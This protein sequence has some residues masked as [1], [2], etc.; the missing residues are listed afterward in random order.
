MHNWCIP[1]KAAIWPLG[2]VGERFVRDLAATLPLPN[3]T[4]HPHLTAAVPS[5]EIRPAKFDFNILSSFRD[6]IPF[7]PHESLFNEVMTS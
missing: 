6:S 4:S 5:S 3:P 1:R 7:N 2:G